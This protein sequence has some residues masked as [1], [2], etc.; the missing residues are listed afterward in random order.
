MDLIQWIENHLSLH[1]NVE[2][3]YV[4][5][6]YE[7]SF[8]VDEVPRHTAHGKTL[9]EALHKLTE[10]VE[11]PNN[12]I[13]CRQSWKTSMNGLTS[14]HRHQCIRPAGHVVETSY[15]SSDCRCSCGAEKAPLR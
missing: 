6:G 12:A 15:K 9:K 10:L 11:P 8:T 13:I 4:V 7:A 14:S 3:L 5:D 1:Y 2:F